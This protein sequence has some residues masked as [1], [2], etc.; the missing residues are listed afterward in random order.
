VVAGKSKKCTLAQAIA[1]RRSDEL[2]TAVLGKP[3]Q[4]PAPDVAATGES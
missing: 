2:G 3:T 4:P 1:R